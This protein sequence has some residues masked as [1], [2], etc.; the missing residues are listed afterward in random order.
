MTLLTS[1]IRIHRAYSELKSE[2]PVKIAIDNSDLLNPEDKL[3]RE[4]LRPGYEILF[5]SESDWNL[6]LRW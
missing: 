2:N 3:L 4:G 1:I 5:V 6:L